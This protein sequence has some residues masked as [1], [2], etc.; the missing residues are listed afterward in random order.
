MSKISL[1]KKLV[2]GTAAG[3]LTGYAASRTSSSAAEADVNSIRG[4]QVGATV[5]AGL[6]SIIPLSKSK[7]LNDATKAAG[8]VIFRRIGGRIIPIRKK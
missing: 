8:K 4:L 7:T 6:A 5:G 1:L 2:K 3:G